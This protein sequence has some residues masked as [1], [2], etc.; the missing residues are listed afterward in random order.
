MF[1]R[2]TAAK[3]RASSVLFFKLLA[4]L[5]FTLF[6]SV[7]SCILNLDEVAS[8]G[9]LELVGL[10]WFRFS[11]DAFADYLLNNSPNDTTPNCTW[12]HLEPVET[13][14]FTLKTQ[15]TEV[16]EVNMT[17]WTGPPTD[18]LETVR[19]NFTMSVQERVSSVARVF[20]DVI[21]VVTCLLCALQQH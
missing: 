13:E 6:A 7:L 21:L 5:V 14:A 8:A 2:R 11:R 12:R 10:T 3:R 4:L 18:V 19:P 17:M 20:A 1:G 9:N 16:V 15:D